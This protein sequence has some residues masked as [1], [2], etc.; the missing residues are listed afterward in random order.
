MFIG[1]YSTAFAA[2][3]AKPAIPLWHLFVAVQLVDFAW[4]VL[5]MIGVEK[6]RI[7]PHFMEASNLD[8]YYM[9]YTHSLPGSL[10]WAIGAGLIYALISG[11]ALKWRAGL[12]FGA[13]VFSH[14][15]LDL[16]VHTQDLALYFG[17]PK[18]GFGL[19]N[20]FLWSQLLEVGLLLGG[21]VIYLMHTT[22]GGLWGR[23]SPWLLLAVLL[24]LQGF[25]HLPVAD[26]PPTPQ[27]FGVLALVGYSVLALAAMFVDMTRRP[28]SA[29]PAE[30]VS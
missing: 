24:G 18:V 5:V 29:A 12:I 8:L 27:S 16:I 9:P 4:A 22:P 13:A 21:M 3:A 1:H 2:R 10:A 19:W 20:S 7:I 14:W 6:V 11:G 30:A 28:K 25:N 23:V 15:L 26:P 17:G